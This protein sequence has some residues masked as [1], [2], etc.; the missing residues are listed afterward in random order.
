M[1]TINGHEITSSTNDLTKAD[2]KDG[3]YGFVIPTDADQFL[4]HI[5]NFYFTIATFTKETSYLHLQW[6]VASDILNEG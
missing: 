1:I 4:Y 2:S 3:K 6:D 5:K